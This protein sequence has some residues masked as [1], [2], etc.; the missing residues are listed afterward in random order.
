MSATAR[1]FAYKAFGFTIQSDIELP[2]LLPSYLNRKGPDITV[3]KTDLTDLWRNKAETDRYFSVEKDFCMFEVSDAAIYKIEKGNVISVSPI[4][5]AP[6]GRIRLYI[7]GTCM[8]ALLMQRSIIPLHGSAVVID[9]KAYAIV[10]DSGAGK[11]TLAAEFLRQGYQLLSD[12]VIPVILNERNNTPIVTP[13]YPQQKLWQES[14]DQFG[15]E[16][17][18]LRP[19]INR[20][21]KFTVPVKDQ[22]INK[23]MPLGGIFELI[24]T[25]KAG[26][27]MKPVQG[28]DSIHRFFHHTYRN[29]LIYRLGLMD[30]HFK[31]SARI[32]SSV[33]FYHLRRPES[34]FTAIELADMILSEVKRGVR[35]V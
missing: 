7:L 15:M 13:S 27:D 31:T 12:D 28:L 21:S 6:E 35:A 14:L 34:C 4:E 17:V 2:E 19:I 1:K 20:K 23:P 22:F 32:M 9:G 33:K 10:G 11:S 25:E 3:Q 16:T 29:F 30:W 24:I 18:G 8:G 5:D 26:L